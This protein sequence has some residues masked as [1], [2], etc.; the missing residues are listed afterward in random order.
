MRFVR[1]IILFSAFGLLASQNVSSNEDNL[2][3]Y[4]FTC[5]KCPTIVERMRVLEECMP[6]CEM[7]LYD[8]VEK[9]NAIRFK[10]IAENL[11]I[12]LY[13][14][15]T[16]IFRN[17]E[18]VALASGEI[19]AKDWNRLYKT[20]V[21]GI[22]VCVASY[23]GYLNV[24]MVINN[25]EVKNALSKLFI[26]PE[27]FSLED[28]S[29]KQ[30]LFV[31]LSAAIIDAI[32]PCSLSIFIVLLSIVFYEAGRKAVLKRGLSFSSG[33]F[34]SYLL[35]GIGLLSIFPNIPGIKYII[36]TLAIILGIRRLLDA[37]GMNIQHF[38]G[39]IIRKITSEIESVSSAFTAYCSGVVMG[40]LFLPCSSIP[41]FIVL[42][43]LSEKSYVIKSIFLIIIYNLIIISPFIITT[44][45]VY[46]LIRTMNDLDVYFIE[47][48]KLINLIIGV[49][50]VFL[51][52]I[53]LIFLNH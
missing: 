3:L 52:I 11:G 43:L 10:R 14:P 44:F 4:V 19:S 45:L 31:V 27:L 36:S 6:N 33:L 18:L 46:G 23:Q 50:F 21:D 42:N 35:L 39:P 17:D 47:K 13:L 24:E 30:L 48:R 34:T 29:S 49:T 40:L 41:Y 22:P 38:P 32:N 8:I 9:E 16:A 12:T 20:K 37:S 51:G 26:E 53:N 7:I 5:M 1:F 25:T 28:F 15:L 2:V